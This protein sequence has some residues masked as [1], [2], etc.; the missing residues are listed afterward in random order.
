MK[1]QLSTLSLPVFVLC[2]VLLS[3][4][5]QYS[6]SR[7]DD[8]KDIKSDEIYA[9]RR[10]LD[11]KLTAVELRSNLEGIDKAILKEKALKGEEAELEKVRQELLKE[12]D[13]AV[14][15]LFDGDIGREED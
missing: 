13:E 12:S 15:G 1:L 14:A 3:A 8:L 11:D 2:L 10:A 6:Q 7:V 4:C 5:G 9:V